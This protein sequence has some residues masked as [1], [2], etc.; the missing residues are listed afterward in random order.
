MQGRI[1][2]ATNLGL[3][4]SQ[5]QHQP[6]PFLPSLPPCA[7]KLDG[8]QWRW[9]WERRIRPRNYCRGWRASRPFRR[10]LSIS[11]T[12]FSLYHQ[13]QARP[14]NTPRFPAMPLPLLCWVVMSGCCWASVST[15]TR[16]GRRGCTTCALC[17]AQLDI[18]TW[19]NGR[20]QAAQ[21]KQASTRANCNRWHLY[22]APFVVK[23]NRKTGMA[24]WHI[25]Y[26]IKLHNTSVHGN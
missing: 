9:H 15:R 25:L 21:A 2:Q 18:Q 16:N 19:M 10:D 4:A 5:N 26:Y 6:F 24:Y 23:A 17:S 1:W 7:W 3:H 20:W 12:L 22:L 8:Q 13:K 14:K 11:L